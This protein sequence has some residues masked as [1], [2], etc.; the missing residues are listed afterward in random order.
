MSAFLDR[1]RQGVPT[2]MLGI[3]GSRTSEIV[4]M[5]HATGHHAILV[6]LEHSPMSTDVAAQLCSAADSLG[7]TALVRVPEREY[8][9]IGRLLDG[10]A[11]GIVAPRIETAEEARLVARAC[12]FPPRGQRSQIAQAPRYG[13]RPMPA[14]E[15]NPALDEEAIVQILIETPAGIANAAA[16]A[17]V[18]GVDMLAIGVNDLT[19]ELGAPGSY[20]DPG[21][22]EAIKT[23]AA[24]CRAHGKLLAI[25]GMPATGL[26]GVCPLRITGMDSALL[27]QAIDAAAKDA[28]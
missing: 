8:G 13:M 2:L 27:Y 24:A 21:V 20:D 15:L 26:A 5:A 17:R 14:R 12:R 28:S 16:I 7:M 4:R 25:G 18:D 3:R 19:A 22:A 9:M 6:D 11:H 1:L 10:G 23:A